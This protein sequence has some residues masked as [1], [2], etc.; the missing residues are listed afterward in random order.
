MGMESFTLDF[1]EILLNNGSGMGMVGRRF[2]SVVIKIG[3][4]D[5]TRIAVGVVFLKIS[6][7]E[8]IGDRKRSPASEATCFL[9]FVKCVPATRLMGIVIAILGGTILHMHVNQ[10]SAI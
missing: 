9:T 3:P 1:I 7:M 8:L 5:S 4:R 6:L 2:P 10:N